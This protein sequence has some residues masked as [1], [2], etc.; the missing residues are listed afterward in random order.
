MSRRTSRGG[1]T[2]QQ[3]DLTV[4]AVP[5]AALVARGAAGR[6][7]PRA[8]RGTRC[9]CCTARS[10]A[11]SR[12][13]LR[14]SSTAA[15]LS[16]R[17]A[18]APESGATWRWALPR[19]APR[20][21]RASGTAGALEYVSSNPW[22]ELR[23]EAATRHRREGLA[24]GGPR[25]RRRDAQ[26]VVPARA[27]SST[28]RRSTATGSVAAE[29]DARDRG[30]GGGGPRRDR[31]PDR[32]P[33]GAQRAAARGA[34]AR[35]RRDPRAGRPR[36]CTSSST[37]GGRRPTADDGSRRAGPPADAARDRARL[38]Q[39]PRRCPPSI[40]REALRAARASS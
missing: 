25:H 30:A 20:W 18:R 33:G 40:D 27:R 15:P 13:P 26:P 23:D 21:R 31:R 32:A 22:G 37:C 36:R 14:A 39:P 5:H 38:P 34:R 19:A 35:P 2:I 4:L 1:S 8:A 12:R 17:R 9:W 7:G 3:L 28:C 29:L 10:R 24:A 16:A 6:S 11:S